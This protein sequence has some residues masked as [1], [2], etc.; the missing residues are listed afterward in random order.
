MFLDPIAEEILLARYAREEREFTETAAAL[1]RP[2]RRY[3]PSVE[4]GD[5][6]LGLHE[7]KILKRAVR[8][9]A[10]CLLILTY[11]LIEV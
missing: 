11:K 7:Q 9:L 8:I 2:V 4:V 5:N 1:P 3:A 6:D 10:T